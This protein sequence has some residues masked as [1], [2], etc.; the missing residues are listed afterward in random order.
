V[1]EIVPESQELS[2][3][4]VMLM[5]GE[6]DL[7]IFQLNRQVAELIGLNQKAAEHL[8]ELLAENK[9]LKDELTGTEK[10]E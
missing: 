6:K 2:L 4:D 7:V 10:E 8:K 9:K 1:T 3:M 5:L